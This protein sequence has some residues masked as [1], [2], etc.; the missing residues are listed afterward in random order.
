M[1]FKAPRIE[2]DTSIELI[3]IVVPILLTILGAS[4]LWNWVTGNVREVSYETRFISDLQDDALVLRGVDLPACLPTSKMRGAADIDGDY[5]A[6][7][8]R[9]NNRTR[10][11]VRESIIVSVDPGEVV[12]VYP[13]TLFGKPCLESYSQVRFDSVDIRP[14]N[15]VT[16]SVITSG[17]LSQATLIEPNFGVDELVQS[18]KRTV[19]F[20]IIVILFLIAAG[21]VR[22]KMRDRRLGSLANEL[23]RLQTKTMELGETYDLKF[24]DFEKKRNSAFE[25][26]RAELKDAFLDARGEIVSK[27]EAITGERFSAKDLDKIL[28]DPMEKVFRLA[29][30]LGEK[31]ANRQIDNINTEEYAARAKQRLLPDEIYSAAKD[32]SVRASL[33]SE[34]LEEVE[35]DRE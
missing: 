1:R 21:A 29:H 30:E 17:L 31:N 34:L 12:G 9:I 2:F 24:K 27:L 4:T 5:V 18:V 11:S 14:R 7:V 35:S 20:V 25:D 10:E 22:D 33:L 32:D 26:H 23:K 13:G 6:H 19:A 8:F 28:A 15:N 3:I 16:F